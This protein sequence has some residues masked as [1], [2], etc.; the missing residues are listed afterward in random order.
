MLINKNKPMPIKCNVNIFLALIIASIPFFSVGLNDY[1]AEVF[2]EYL[3]AEKISDLYLSGNFGYFTIYPNFIALINIYSENFIQPSTLARFSSFL[4]L[5]LSSFFTF[6]LITKTKENAF[7]YVVSFLSFLLLVL[8][9]SLNSMITIG[10]FFYLPFLL[11]FSINSF[12]SKDGIVPQ[13]IYSLALVGMLS[14]PT[15]IFLFALKFFKKNY[16]FVLSIALIF[17]IQYLVYYST[18]KQGHNF[19]AL[20]DYLISFLTVAGSVVSYLFFLGEFWW[21]R[22]TNILP[23]IGLLFICLFS[24]FYFI[25]FKTKGYINLFYL[26]LGFGICCSPIVINPIIDSG[27][28]VYSSA[29]WFFSKYKL[30]YRILPIFYFVSV[31]YLLFSEFNK[32]RLLT[33]FLCF[34]L[35]FPILNS[36]HSA[37]DN[38]VSNTFVLDNKIE[39]EF[40]KKNCFINPPFPGWGYEMGSTNFKMTSSL[41]TS[42]NCNTFV[43]YN[44][45]NSKHFLD[46]NNFA[47]SSNISFAKILFIYNPNNKKISFKEAGECNLNIMKMT[48]DNDYLRKNNVFNYYGLIVKDVSIDSINACHQLIAK[49]NNIQIKDLNYILTY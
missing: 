44:T 4:V 28:I 35:A 12:G 5:F 36:I 34:A 23:F 38:D 30:Q 48:K 33:Y 39:R 13:K 11:F 17:I 15:L 6:S 46:Q 22:S 16:L 10:Y 47:V 43:K 27:N 32:H 7:F 19:I 29:F 3:Q 18:N 2:I 37:F 42:G 31:I 26:I 9:P 1:W 14:K 45:Y 8:H 24:F 21:M 25:K 40:N 20:E 41:W 49:K